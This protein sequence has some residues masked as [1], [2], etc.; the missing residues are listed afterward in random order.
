MTVQVLL[1]LAFPCGWLLAC[2]WLVL[3]SRL[4][5]QLSRIEPAAYAALGK[6]LTPWL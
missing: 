4:L 6:L 2:F 3:M 1:V 5:H